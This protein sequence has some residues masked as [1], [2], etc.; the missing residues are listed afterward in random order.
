M[1]FTCLPVQQQQCGVDYVNIYRTA[2]GSSAASTLPNSSDTKGSTGHSNNSYLSAGDIAGIGIGSAAVALAIAFVVLYMVARRRST[3][4]TTQKYGA[5]QPIMAHAPAPDAPS[6]TSISSPN[7][8]DYYQSGNVGANFSP[9]R[10]D[11][12]R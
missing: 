6:S 5:I 11:Y 2:N 8:P 4:T 12:T 9:N 10:P 7:P 1:T 3:Q